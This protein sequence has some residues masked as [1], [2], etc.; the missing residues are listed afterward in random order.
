MRA[1]KKHVKIPWLK[2]YIERWLKAPFQKPNGR[3]E[4]RSKGTPQGGVISPVLA[5]LF[6]HYAFDKW[7]ERTHPD[8][9]FARYA[10]DGVIHCR[11][12]EEAQLLLESLKERMEE[13]KLE[14][15]PEKTRIVYC[16]DD[17]RKDEYP[18]TSFDFLGY[19]FR[20]RSCKDRNG[21]IFY[22]FTPAVSEQAKKAMR[23][24]IRRMRLQTKSYLSIE[25][26]SERINP[27]IRGW[28]N[29][30]GHFRRFEMYTVLS[31]LNKALVQW[32]RNKY[33]KR[34]GLTKAGKWLE[35]LAR[36]EPHLFVHWTMGIFYMAG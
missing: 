16:K 18:N 22:S 7:M 11:T 32:V 27:V 17:K 26:L 1:V 23:Q 29:Y 12:L 30:Y 19:T 36:R 31:R 6:M 3:V 35:A 15:H 13:C 21:R 14:L 25:E 8:K 9:P 20:V 24:K 34:R 2:L 33:K 5:N 28:I 4:E 10:D